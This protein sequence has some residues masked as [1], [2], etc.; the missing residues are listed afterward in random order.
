[1]ADLL[2]IAEVLPLQ[3]L[4]GIKCS[5][6]SLVRERH[7]LQPVALYFWYARRAA[8]SLRV[9]AALHQGSVPTTADVDVLNS[10]WHLDFHQL[11]GKRGQVTA[12]S[13]NHPV[14]NLKFAN[15]GANGSRLKATEIAKHLLQWELD[16]W[17][18]AGEVNLRFASIGRLRP[19]VVV[20]GIGLWG[21]IAR[22]LAF[23]CSNGRPMA[24]C[25]GCNRLFEPKRKPR[26]GSRSWCSRPG[27]GTTAR[28]RAAK[29]DERAR[30]AV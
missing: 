24:V 5:W 23:R 13:K 10:S 6:E 19:E 25:A 9:A 27:C 21:V 8:A 4:S 1:M 16:N 3:P 22:Q 17:L 14:L 30:T 28:W 26:A 7:R 29:R 11:D 15:A 2:T 12:L 18:R 20:T